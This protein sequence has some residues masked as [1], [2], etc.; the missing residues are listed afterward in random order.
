MVFRSPPNTNGLAV[1]ISRAGTNPPLTRHPS[2]SRLLVALSPELLQRW[3]RCLE[4]RVAA[5]QLSGSSASARQ[6]SSCS[7]SSAQGPVPRRC[8]R[9]MAD[10]APRV[11]ASWWWTRWSTSSDS[12]SC[13]L[14]LAAAGLAPRCR[15]AGYMSISM[16]IRIGWWVSTAIAATA[17]GDM[18][19]N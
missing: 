3:G 5:L 7:S 2:F 6:P 8:C 10:T 4:A 14:E 18:Q 11:D 17:S 13:R 15:A 9:M 16:H 12:R 1:S 19:Q